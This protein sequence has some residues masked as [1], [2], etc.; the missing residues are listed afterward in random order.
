M[1]DSSTPYEILEHYCSID[2]DG[3]GYEEPYIVY[4]RRDTKKVA[5]IVP[6]YF[7]N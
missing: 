2:F 7:E 5:R 1:V 4:V 3:D 6:R